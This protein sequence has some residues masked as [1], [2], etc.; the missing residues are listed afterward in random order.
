MNN[1]A[2]TVRAEV[3]AGLPAGFPLPAEFTI[4]TYPGFR[5]QPQA[6]HHKLVLIA[7][8]LLLHQL[9][10]IILADATL[11]IPNLSHKLHASLA[12]LVTPGTSL[13][14]ALNSLT[15]GDSDLKMYVAVATDPAVKL[16]EAK[17]WGPKVSAQPG[18]LSA[19][20][21]LAL[22][23]VMLGYVSSTGLGRYAGRW[24]ALWQVVQQ[25]AL[26]PKLLDYVPE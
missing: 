10:H 22:V 13:H 25:C 12:D 5:H 15:L 23:R 17:L 8:F 6:F 21:Y 24:G 14:T 26:C 7:R 3:D 9:S 16:A 18:E 19:A 1:L 11:D 4:E 2:W 20:E